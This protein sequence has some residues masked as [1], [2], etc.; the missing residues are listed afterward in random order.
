MGWGPGTSFI[1][2]IQTKDITEVIII[3]PVPNKPNNHGQERGGPAGSLVELAAPELDAPELDL[4]FISE[5]QLLFDPQ[6]HT[7]SHGNM[8]GTG[9][10][11]CSHSREHG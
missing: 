5:E 6:R 3:S 8:E 9:R 10:L 7:L 11:S 1:P 2:V 4:V